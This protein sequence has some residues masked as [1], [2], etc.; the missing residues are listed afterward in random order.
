MPCHAS[1][2]Q[3][4]AA[5][6]AGTDY[7]RR[8][9]RDLRADALAGRTHRAQQSYW[10]CTPAGLGEAA[11]SGELPPTSGRTIGQRAATKRGLR[12]HGLAL[13]DTVV[14]FRQAQ[15]AEHTDWRL[16]RPPTSPPAGSLLPD[17]G[18]LL[19]NGQSAFVEIDRT[20]SYAR[21]VAKLER[22]DAYRNAP[23]TGRGNAARAAWATG[24]PWRPRRWPQLTS[25]GR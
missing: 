6:P 19:T 10:Y 13:V 12:E 21:L 7:V 16:A 11:A 18:V 5:G 1:P 23:A 24:S 4:P 8:A 9:L 20:M 15:A 2:A 3:G 17:A 22:Y 14:T 25:T